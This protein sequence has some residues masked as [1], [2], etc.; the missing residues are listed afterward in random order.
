MPTRLWSDKLLSTAAR[1]GIWDP[2]TAKAALQLETVQCRAARWVKND[3][4]QQSS[5]TSILIDLKWWNLAQ[6]RTD[7]RLLLI[8][9]I[10]HNL[11]LR[12]AIQYVTLQRSLINLQQILTNKKYYEMSCILPSYSQRLEFPTKSPTCR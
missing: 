6:R 1:F 4:V 3:Y 2:H 8:Y 7:A 5:V 10:V 12:E 11:I 9:K